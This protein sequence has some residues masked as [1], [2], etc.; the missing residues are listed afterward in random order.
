VIEAAPRV[1]ARVASAPKSQFYEARHRAEGV[2]LILNASVSAIDSGRVMLAD[3]RAIESDAVVIGIG[4]TAEDELARG[5]GLD[6][7]DGVLVDENCRSS[8]PLIFAAGDVA[9]PFFPSA[10]RRLRIEAVATAISQA[11]TVAHAILGQ[12]RPRP[13]T[14][15]FWSDQYDLKLQIAGLCFP[16]DEILVRKRSGGKGFSVL[17]MRAGQ[18]QGIESVNNAVDFMTVRRQLDKGQVAIDKPGASNGDAPLAAS[19]L[20]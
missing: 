12:P 9:K 20:A 7:D 8:D 2:E 11:K 18:L 15:W 19:F 4:V 17:H 10:N 3:G 13:E 16:D 6:C 1:L 14:P 5:A